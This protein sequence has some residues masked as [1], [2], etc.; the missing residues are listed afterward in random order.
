MMDMDRDIGSKTTNFGN[1]FP[2]FRIV[3]VLEKAK[4]AASATWWK[5]FPESGGDKF[6]D[7]GGSEIPRR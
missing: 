7:R 5:I 2:K 1:K 6:K 4:S 3:V